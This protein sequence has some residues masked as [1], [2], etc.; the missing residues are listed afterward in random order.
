MR[1]GHTQFLGMPRSVQCLVVVQKYS[2]AV[3]LQKEVVEAEIVSLCATAMEI[4]DVGIGS[5]DASAST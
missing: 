5:T 2:Q 3:L 4:L 1:D